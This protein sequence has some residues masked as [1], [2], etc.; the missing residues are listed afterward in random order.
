M[1]LLY[2]IQGTGNG[3]IS[4]A[5]EVLPHLKKH[6]EV[7][8]LISGE[9][10]ELNLPFHPDFKFQGLGFVF[11]KKGGI[12]LVE[13]YRKNKLKRFYNEVK[14]LN[15][16]PY[17]FVISDFEPITAWASI[18]QGKRCFGLSNQVSLLEPKVPKSK[19]EDLVGRFI[20]RHYAPCAFNFGLSYR[21][22]QENIY[23]PII[24][25]SLRDKALTNRGHY[26]LY[27]PSYSDEKILST[28]KLLNG[29]KW[30]VF[31][32]K[33]K[34]EYEVGNIL[35]SPLSQV[36]FERSI[37][38]CDGIVTA[39]GFGT[40]TEALFMG[41]KLLVVPQKNQYEQACNAE[42]LKQ[43]GIDVLKSWK[44]KHVEKIRDWVDFKKPIKVHYPDVTE[45]LVSDMLFT[46]HSKDDPYTSYLTQ[47]QYTLKRV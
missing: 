22:Y 12:D 38:S 35:I 19:K 8:V 41:K 13:T 34:S 27:L 14:A 29:V 11:G 10:S 47:D 26:T 32:K 36:R 21:A 33:R 2:G 4:R 25:K 16:A 24:R 23:T 39:A 42:A 20:I 44:P 31:S 30:H 37:A 28:L 45:K 7:D 1:R 46:F 40:T 17:D 43:L 15:L 18:Q 5:I 3:H 9:Q 6:A